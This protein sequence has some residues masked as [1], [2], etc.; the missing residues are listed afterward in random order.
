[1]SE[2]S[3]IQKREARLQRQCD[4]ER[5]RHAEET[6]KQREIR[7]SRRRERDRAEASESG[8]DADL[9]SYAYHDHLQATVWI[10]WAC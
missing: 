9:S 8:S 5:Q 6:A 4:H 7:L 1:M 10:V 2:T 3:D